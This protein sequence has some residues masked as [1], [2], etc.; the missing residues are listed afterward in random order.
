[1]DFKAIQDTVTGKTRKTVIAEKAKKDSHHLSQADH[2]E[3]DMFPLGKTVEGDS[4]CWN[5]FASP[6]IFTYGDN[7]RDDFLFSI[8]LHAKHYPE[9]WDVYFNELRG[10]IPDYSPYGI[11]AVK[12]FDNTCE[13]I[14]DIEEEMDRRLARM[15]ENRCS[16]YLG[17][18]DTKG[19][20]VL[21]HEIHYYIALTGNKS[22]EG[23]EHDE[24]RKALGNS[25]ER[26][27]FL[28]G[29]AGIH[30][31]STTVARGPYPDHKR[32]LKHCPFRLLLDPVDFSRDKDESD[33]HFL[34]SALD[35]SRELVDS[36]AGWSSYASERGKLIQYNQYWLG[37]HEQCEL[38]QTLVDMDAIG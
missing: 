37:Y 20:L 14:K 3:W 31:I 6:H 34:A 32:L 38:L 28:G 25:L 10:F 7:K 2:S 21:F 23:R 17:L 30:L 1:M 13:M 5:P 22:D 35:I 27:A 15:K 9:K 18:P 12:E 4:F 29:S 33:K 24:K 19:L 36:L 16:T 26:I 8:I 11:H